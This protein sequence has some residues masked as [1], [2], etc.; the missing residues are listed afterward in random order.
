MELLK[1]E[2]NYGRKY[3]YN[4]Y[5]PIPKNCKKL[6]QDVRITK[7]NCSELFDYNLE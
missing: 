1:G 6:Y 5:F 3:L 4:I 7:L 2:I